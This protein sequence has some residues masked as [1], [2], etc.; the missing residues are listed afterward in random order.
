MKSITLTEKRKE[1]LLDV[2]ESE[3]DHQKE[4]LIYAS[5]RLRKQVQDEIKEI[6]SMLAIIS[7]EFYGDE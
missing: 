7:P 5:G 4:I 2:L 1:I 3:L 6:K